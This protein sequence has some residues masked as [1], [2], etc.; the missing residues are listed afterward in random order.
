MRIG[1]SV[2]VDGV[3]RHGDRAAARAAS[4][5]RSVGADVL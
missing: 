5:L 2:I 3:G 1:Y 4:N